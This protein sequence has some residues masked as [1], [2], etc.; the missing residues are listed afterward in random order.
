MNVLCVNDLNDLI[1]W[2]DNTQPQTDYITRIRRDLV[3]IAIAVNG[4]VDE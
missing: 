2:I 1:H 4:G 3:K